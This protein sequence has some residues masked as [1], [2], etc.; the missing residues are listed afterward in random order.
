MEEISDMPSS[1]LLKLRLVELDE[2]PLMIITSLESTAM[3]LLL[4]SRKVIR[5]RRSSV[6]NNSFL[7]SGAVRIFPP[8]GPATLLLCS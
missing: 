2:S 5:T 6:M 4:S 1:A 8:L 7:K 3:G